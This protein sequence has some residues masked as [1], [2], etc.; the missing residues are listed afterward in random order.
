MHA[1]LTFMSIF[2]KHVFPELEQLRLVM[3]YIEQRC[4]RPSHAHWEGHFRFTEIEEDTVIEEKA[5]VY[6]S[7]ELHKL[8][9]I[10]TAVVFLTTSYK[11][12]EC[13]KQRFLKIVPVLYTASGFVTLYGFILEL[14]FWSTDFA[15]L[16]LP[17]QTVLRLVTKSF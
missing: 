11:F 2:Y 13:T 7:I 1:V 5:I 16:Y 6:E 12:M 17:A 4:D 8:C 10:N 3:R 9:T 15:V 14:W